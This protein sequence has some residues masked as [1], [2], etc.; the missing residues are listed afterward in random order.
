MA[1]GRSRIEAKQIAKGTRKVRGI[2]KA[3]RMGGFGQAASSRNVLQ[4]RDQAAPFPVTAQRQ[5][6]L[7]NEPMRKPRR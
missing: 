5:T 1:Q 6:G 7:L 4:R 2:S 3:G